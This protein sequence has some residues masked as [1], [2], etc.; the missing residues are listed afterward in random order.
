MKRVQKIILSVGVTL[1]L[2]PTSS[3]ALVSTDF[4]TTT[5]EADMG[6]AAIAAITLAVIGMGFA[7]VKRVLN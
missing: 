4:V 7:F 5:A 3:F 1:A 6:L 2:I